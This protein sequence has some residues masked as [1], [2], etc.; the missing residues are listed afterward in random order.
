MKIT[1]ILNSD[2]RNE[3]VNVIR[4][5]SQNDGL[6]GTLNTET[7]S[8]TLDVNDG[9]TFAFVNSTETNENKDLTDNETGDTLN[10]A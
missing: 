3:S 1:L 6:I 9:E 2:E 5:D 8:L 10:P 7:S 4:F